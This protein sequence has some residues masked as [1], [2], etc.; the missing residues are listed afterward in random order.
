MS[1]K[2]SSLILC[3][4]FSTA[5][6]VAAKNDKAPKTESKLTTSQTQSMEQNTT[7]PEQKQESPVQEKQSQIYTVIDAQ[8]IIMDTGIDK[9]PMQKLT[10]LQ[11]KYQKEL[12]EMADTALK[13]EQE[14]KTKGSTL[15]PEAL[16]TKQMEL[17]E[18]NQKMQLRLNYAN[19]ALREADVKARTEIFQELQKHAQEALVNKQGYKIV[20]ERSGGIIAFA[21]EADSSDEITKVVK[22]DLEKKAKTKEVKTKDTKAKNSQTQTTEAPAKVNNSKMV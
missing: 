4:L 5:V 7:A 1:L 15:A 9:E 12:K 22:A 19:N 8:K 6:L 3:C 14:L 2:Q 16:K 18:Q 10:E 20:F 17:E 21:P 13:L 11:Q